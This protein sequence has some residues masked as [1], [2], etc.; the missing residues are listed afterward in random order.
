MRWFHTC[1]AL[2]L[3]LPL[4]AAGFITA[5]PGVPLPGQP[6]TFTLR[7]IPDP[8]GEVRWSFGDGTSSMGAPI[9]MTTYTT[10]GSYTVRAVYRV[11]NGGTLSLPQAAQTQVRVAD[12]PA[13]P[14]TLSQLRL[15]WADGGIDVTV[16]QGF[17]PLAAYLDLKCEGTGMFLA[18]WTVDGIPIG[19]VSRPLTFA[20]TVS[21]DTRELL[22]LPTSEPG[23]HFVSLR[24]LAPQTALQVPTIRYF[25]HLDRGAPPRIDE[26]LPSLLRPGEEAEL[27]LTGK[28]LAPGTRL[29]FGKDIA[30]VTQLRILSPD[31]ALARVYVSPGAKPGFRPALARDKRGESRGPGGLRIAAPEA[32]A[33]QK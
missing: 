25:V 31:K 7:A 26:V 1:L 6:V 18:Q 17:S 33:P 14:F 16:P 10:P 12:Y 19:T 21:L 32:Q 2:A 3:Y 29:S 9:T 22:P 27:Q 30:L 28:G 23:E 11:L 15:R 13:A 8:V 4:P 20:A 24:I 5:S